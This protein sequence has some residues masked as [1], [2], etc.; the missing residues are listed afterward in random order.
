MTAHE[1]LRAGLHHLSLGHSL[2]PVGRNKRPHTQALKATGH[3]R[4]NPEGD[5]R[6]SWLPLQDAPPDE[7]TLRRWL[8]FPDT[9]LGLITGAVS[10]LVIIDGDLGDGIAKFDRWGVTPRCHVRTISGGLHY[11]VK[12]PGW[13]VKTVQTHTGASADLIHGVDIRG[14]GGYAVIPPTA[15]AHGRYHALRGPGEIDDPR[16]LPDDVLA[17]ISLLEPPQASAVGAPV[18]ATSVRPGGAGGASFEPLAPGQR[19]VGR[20]GTPIDEELLARACRRALAGDS[21]EGVGFELAK[22]LRD[23]RLDYHEA[24]SVLERYVDHAPPHNTKGQLVPYT[25]S[26][27]R[28]S[29]DQAYSRAPRAPWAQRVTVKP[30]PPSLAAR[31][32]AVWP[33]LG[34]RDR[35]LACLYAAGM[36]GGPG[37]LRETLEALG[38]W[39]AQVANA[40]VARLAA[41]QAVPGT[42]ALVRLI[43]A[44]EAGR[45]AGGGQA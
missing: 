33:A 42:G 9:G 37:D 36:R 11:Y 7:A 12:H 18:T 24:W 25:L 15:F 22:Q 40:A 4:T 16:W 27:A 23:N 43:T 19:W 35:D 2:L 8:R 41:G 31:L 38:G 20:D 32:S 21:R 34:P 1:L 14:D 17:A 29:L 5:V 39:N 26:Q 30:G 28:T 13:K 6:G 10:G 44:A 3:T 45:N